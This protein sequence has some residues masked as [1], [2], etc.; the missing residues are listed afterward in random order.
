MPDNDKSIPKHD[1]P[2]CIGAQSTVII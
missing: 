2:R 1:N